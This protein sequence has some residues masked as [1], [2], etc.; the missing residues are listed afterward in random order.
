MPNLI[1]NHTGIP[2]QQ[3]NIQDALIK[4]KA[5]IEAKIREGGTTAKNNFIKTQEPIKLIHNAVKTAFL[6]SGIHPSLINPDKNRLK[7]VINPPKRKSNSPIK[8][9][10]KE[11]NLAGFLKTKPQDIS[12]I[13][14]NI[15]I[16]PFTFEDHPS[17]LNDYVDVYGE[18]LTEAI[19]TVNVRS[20][21]SSVGK[22]FNTLYERTFAESLNLHLRFPKMVLGELFLIIAKQYNDTEANKKIVDFKGASNLEKYIKAFQTINNRIKDDDEKYKYERCCLMIVDFSPDTP[23]IYNSTDEL[24][25]DDLLPNLSNVSME[26]LDYTN[27]VPDLLKIYK[28]RFPDNT[29]N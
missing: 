22:N 8:L 5:D 9:K 10:D 2:F 24:K 13:P 11:L 19:I 28:D 23:K 17:L 3:I 6:N 27:F 12:I 16:A 25:A 14:R 15:K 29:F 7:K 18:A 21:L 20:Q 26:N 4:I 1:D